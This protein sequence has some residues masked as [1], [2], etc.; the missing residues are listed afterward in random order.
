MGLMTGGEH[1]QIRRR[2]AYRT[3]ENLVSEYA[4][5]VTSGGCTIKA[6][7]PIELGSNFVFEMRAEQPDARGELEIEGKVVTVRA[8]DQ[9]FE[10]GIEY[11]PRSTRD[12]L[13]AVLAQIR[14]DSSFAVLRR[15]P[16]IPVNLIVHDRHSAETLTIRDLS[17]GGMQLEGAS[18]SWRAIGSGLAV[19]IM[20]GTAQFSIRGAIT[21][22]RGGRI[23]VAF[24][25]FGDVELMILD[26]ML[27][28]L[29]PSGV[30]IRFD[31]PPP[32]SSD[33]AR[34]G[35]PDIEVSVAMLSAAAID[36]LGRLPGELAI[37]ADT[38]ALPDLRSTM[39]ARVAIAG[40]VEGEIAIEAELGL[41]S[42]LARAVLGE[43][44][45]DDEIDLTL[46]ADAL[47]E[48][49][50]MIGGF[51]CD[52]IEDLCVA[53][54]SAPIASVREHHPGAVG[55]TYMFGNSAGRARL[56]IVVHPSSS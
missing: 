17:R 6:P 10:I 36:Y 44:V 38:P 20:L 46:I 15:H 54:V 14:V 30:G 48:L 35:R 45:A 32:A 28:L 26:G 21:W 1:R 49:A 7:R 53:S 37:F 47:S 25:S 9:D 51:A 3:V 43:A 23:G 39:R 33:D 41:C 50:T 24:D 2:I 11:R 8:V 19:E 55:R 29:R 12:V 4:R 42:T 18:L 31:D 52:A 40:G 16:R 34:A 56:T 22:N 27:R 13:E 5:C